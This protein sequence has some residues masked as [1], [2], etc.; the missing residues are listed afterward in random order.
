MAEEKE[1]AFVLPDEKVFVKPNYNNPGWIKNKNHRAFFLMEGTSIRLMAPMKRSGGIANVLTKQE[2]ITLENLLHMKNDEL[3]V[4]RRDDN[5]WE[6]KIVTLNKD[7]KQLD[8][9]DPNDYIEYKILMHNKD[10]VAPSIKN[11]KDRATYKFYIERPSEVTSIKSEKAQ[12]NV[13][14]WRAFGK[15][16][17]DKGKVVD[18]LKVY[19]E[20]FPAYAKHK[21][22]SETENDLDFLS[23]I[24]SEIVEQDKE[25]FVEVSQDPLFEAKLL[26]SKCHNKGLITKNANKYYIKGE[27]QPFASSLKGACEFIEAEDHQDFKL[28]LETKLDS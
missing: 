26:V 14:A 20:S 16:A 17:N 2:K 15:I 10:L 3:S 13:D 12:V 23:T 4:Y 28:T 8:L 27:P 24:L 21:N 18:M 9:S 25:L 22:L 11:V 5:F 1:K 7:T 6:T 19:G